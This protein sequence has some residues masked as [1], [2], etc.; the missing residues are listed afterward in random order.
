[1]P[2]Y[3][4]R[5]WFTD[6]IREVASGALKALSATRENGLIYVGDETLL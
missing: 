6:R 1:M 2:N 5:S 3:G 4:G